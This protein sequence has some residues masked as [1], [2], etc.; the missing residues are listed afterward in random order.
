MLVLVAVGLSVITGCAGVN[1]RERSTLSQ[2]CY[3][4][5]E[6]FGDKPITAHQVDGLLEEVAE[7]LDIT[8]DPAKPKVRIVVRPSSYIQAISEGVA[9]AGYGSQVRALYFDGANLVVIPYYSRTILG[10]E[11]AHYLTDHYLGSTP[12]RQWERIARTVEDALPTT[13]PRQVRGGPPRADTEVE[14]VHDG[15]RIP[16]LRH[17]VPGVIDTPGSPK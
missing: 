4:T 8:L 17:A 12:R 6:N 5:V 15:C 11:L 1:Y 14:D 2:T 3:S 10:H 9:V 16:T 13:A 7:I